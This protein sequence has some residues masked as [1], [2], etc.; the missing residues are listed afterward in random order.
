MEG[1]PHAAGTSL[2]SSRTT[3]HPLG[4]RRFVAALEYAFTCDEYEQFKG[5]GNML[6][7]PGRRLTRL[8]AAAACALGFAWPAS[9]ELI[10][11]WKT[12][13]CPVLPDKGAATSSIVGVMQAPI[14]LQ[15]PT[16]PVISVG[17]PFCD[18]ITATKSSTFLGVK[19]WK[20]HNAD[21]V[22]SPGDPGSANPGEVWDCVLCNYAAG[23][24]NQFPTVSVLGTAI[25]LGGL[26]TAAVYELRRRQS[27]ATAA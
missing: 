18:L 27:R 1:L 19:T 4:S 23:T 2:P 7:S 3:S 12:T 6:P 25:L 13:D 17:G 10:Y 8:L 16:G 20:V 11:M 24:G 26:L 21:I 14:V 15:S 9:A 22:A 5:E